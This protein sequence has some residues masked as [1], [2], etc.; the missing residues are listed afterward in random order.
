MTFDKLTIDDVKSCA[1]TK[2]ARVWGQLAGQYGIW[3]RTSYV[4][5]E[6]SVTTNDVTRKAD[7]SAQVLSEGIMCKSAVD[8]D[9]VGVKWLLFCE[10]SICESL[11]VSFSGYDEGGVLPPFAL[12]G[13]RTAAAVW[14][15]KLWTRLQY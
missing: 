8:L 7:Y 3:I 4:S 6:K 1:C 9:C 11:L 15:A 10:A 13:T 12:M 5:F 2:E 14:A